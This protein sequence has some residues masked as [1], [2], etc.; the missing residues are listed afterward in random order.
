MHFELPYELWSMIFS[1]F[2]LKEL[3]KSS[4]VCRLWR[5]YA[6]AHLSMCRARYVIAKWRS[7]TRYGYTYNDDHEAFRALF[8]N[9][10]KS[11][12][13][14][15]RSKAILQSPSSS[16]EFNFS[17]G[18]E[19]TKPPPERICIPWYWKGAVPLKGSWKGMTTA[20]VPT[21]D[22]CDAFSARGRSITKIALYFEDTLLWAHYCMPSTYVCCF[23]P[24]FI[25]V[26]CIIMNRVQVCVQ[27]EEVKCIQARCG[28]LHA[29]EQRQAE[30]GSK[31]FIRYND[32]EGLLTSFSYAIIQKRDRSAE[33]RHE[34]VHNTDRF[35]PTVDAAQRFAPS[36]ESS[37]R[38]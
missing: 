23:L 29:R 12:L 5:T 27:G 17:M 35:F 36:Y 34:G 7:Y 6:Q 9:S 25:P 8:A 26:R 19:W 30:I 15:R 28:L 16:Y 13:R 10:S 18:W 24:F 38:D 20:W 32:S 37:S 11:D 31:L 22:I 14:M 21:S 33:R 4:K 1:Q 3:R 2:C